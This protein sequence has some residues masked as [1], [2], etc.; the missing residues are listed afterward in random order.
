MGIMAL[1]LCLVITLA[2]FV[3]MAPL[4]SFTRI[5]GHSGRRMPRHRLGRQLTGT[6]SPAGVNDG[7][8]KAIE[9][10]QE[11]IPNPRAADDGGRRAAGA[12]LEPRRSRGPG[13]LG[14]DE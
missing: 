8:K 4:L 9:D 2:A 6:R 3:L 13:G 7:T 11:R 10:S 12:R 14:R 5:L 1:V